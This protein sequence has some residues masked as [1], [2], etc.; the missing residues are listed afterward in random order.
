MALSC[1]HS[2]LSV[3]LS[4][5]Q[6]LSQAGAAAHFCAHSTEWAQCLLQCGKCSKRGLSL[7]GKCCGCQRDLG[8]CSFYLIYFQYGFSKYLCPVLRPA[9]LSFLSAAAKRLNCICSEAALYHLHLDKSPARPGKR[10]L[11]S[12]LFLV[13]C[14]NNRSWQ[15]N[16]R[17]A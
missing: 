7:P 8:S 6:C 16:P 13:S 10:N 1:Q 11:A 4:Q 5:P 12:L 15:P 14:V 9:P 3:C 2:C 17:S